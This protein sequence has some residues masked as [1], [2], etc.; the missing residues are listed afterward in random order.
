[1]LGIA[2]LVLAGCGGGAGGTVAPGTQSL[3]R[4]DVNPHPRDQIRDGGDL[5]LPFDLF[6]ANFNYN[7]IDGASGSL[8]QLTDATLP[9]PFTDA[10]DGGLTPDPDYVT[11]AQVT[12]TSPQVVTYAINP[13]AT[14]S[15]GTPITWRDFQ[16][17][18]HSLNGT[19]PA[20][21]IAGT[22][23]YDDI[24]SVTRGSDDKQVVV[25]FAKPYGEWQ[26]L[27]NP[28]TPASLNSTPAAFNSAWKTSLPVTAGPFTVQSIDLTTSTVT[29]VRDPKWWGTPAKLDHIIFKVYDTAAEPDALAN[30]ELDWYP[31]FANLDLFRRAQRIAGAVIRNAPGRISDNVTLNGAATS[32]LA[33]LTLR[34]AIAQSLNRQEVVRRIISQIVP[35]ATTDGSHL[36][37]PGSKEYQDNAGALPYD[38]AHAQ[39]VLDQLGW[40]RPSP[41]APRTK[42][43]QSLT[44]RLIYG[45]GSATGD[46]NAK[47][48][49][50][51]LA[52]IGVTVVLEKVGANQLFPDYIDRGNFDLALFGWESTASPFSSSAGVYQLPLGDNVRQNYGRVG[53]PEIDALIDQG[54]AELDNTKRAAIGNQA[55]RLIWQQAHSVIFY[56]RPGAVAERANL[57]NFGA[58]GFAETDYIDAGFLK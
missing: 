54:N 47:T 28:L 50:N 56:A 34:Q 55:D 20:Y 19:D 32:P 44:L 30:N 48:V 17:Y 27:F 14:W 6:P 29:L 15:D 1:L 35:D 39:Q 24:S 58:K 4:T 5:R 23:G 3:G 42:N 45:D 13:K 12:S 8:G 21:Q 38:P 41:T 37:P 33:D 2:T 51:Q 57:A 52:Q 31:I 7:E 49:Q 9:Q 11:S 36:Y 16:A 25:T 43:G 46:S 53:S 18:W 26:G 22:T 40:I 10:A